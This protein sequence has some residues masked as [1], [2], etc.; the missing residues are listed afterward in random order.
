MEDQ[1]LYF[2]IYYPRTQIEQS[3]DIILKLPD[4]K[5]EKPEWIYSRS[6]FDSDNNK[7]IIDYK[8]KFKICKSKATGKEADKYYFEFEIG[9]D[10]YIQSLL[11]VKRKNLFMKFL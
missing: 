2:F 10:R 7:K 11:I 5:K 1:Y 8:K 3:S 9:D 6:T 4:N